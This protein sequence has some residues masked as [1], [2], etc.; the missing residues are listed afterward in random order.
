M[1]GLERAELIMSNTSLY[2]R[3]HGISLGLYA[4]DL[5]HLSEAAE[6]A[7]GWG[8]DIL[9]FDVMDGCFVPSLSAGPGFVKALNCGALRDVHLMVAHPLDHIAAF[10]AAGADII[11]VH[12]ESQNAGD[13]LD[14]IKK[15]ASTHKKTVLAGLALMPGTALADIEPLLALK[16]DMILV[17]SL[18]PRNGAKPDIAKACERIHVLRERFGENGPIL[19]FDGGVTLDS[20]DEIAASGVDMIVSGSAV[21]KAENPAGAFREMAKTLTP[22][23]PDGAEN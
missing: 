1:T 3:A 8:C 11:T 19:A 14:L 16:P 22:L 7:V 17:L 23:A 13:A 4:A 12:A 6:I 20:I 5:G 15:T 2:A 18:D 10:V 9:H 21:F